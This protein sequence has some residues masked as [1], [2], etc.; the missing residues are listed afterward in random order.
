MKLVYFQD[1]KGNFGDDLNPWLW[2]R[3]LP[4]QIDGDAS[5]GLLLGVGTIL[6]PWFVEELDPQAQKYV[7][8]SGGGM[9]V[10]PIIPD[11]TWQIHAVRGPLTAAYLGLDADRAA[12]DPAM[13]VGR[14]YETPSRKT[15]GVG[16]MPHHVALRQWDW[17]KTCDD[18][19]LIYLDPH[20]DPIET[21]GKIAN[22]DLVLA[23]A[24]H[25]AIVADALRIPWI[26][27]QINPVN[28]VGKWHDWGAS[29]RVP[30]HFQPLPN[31][32]DPLRQ[33][34]VGQLLEHG[35]RRTVYEL[36][37]K[38]SAREATK[39]VER[40]QALAKDYQSFIS[41]DEDFDRAVSDFEE[42][43]DGFNRTL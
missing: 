23:D 42:R 27:V 25:A 13:C 34:T 2:E 28:Y 22:C 20:A 19:G 37:R 36:R 16:F 43:L 8:G 41:K 35:P 30:M 31:L 29:I 5:S 10:P 3:L 40:L 24:M 15:G 9:T 11:E 39:A 6:E 7:I 14:Y 18:A 26:P 4:R 21:F 33:T 32:Y 12:T 38:S 1:P 17:R